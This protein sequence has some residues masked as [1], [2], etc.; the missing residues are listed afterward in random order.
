MSDRDDFL[1][2]LEARL[3]PAERALHD[4]DAE[5][6]FAIWSRSSPVTVLGAWKNANG[7]D[8]VAHLF[9]ELEDSF[10]DCRSYEFE[11]LVADVVGDMA[12]TVGYEHVRTSLWGKPRTFTLRASQAYRREAGDWKVAHRHADTVTSVEE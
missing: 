9:R 4:G 12:I 1:A 6:R 7:P 8:E 2:W 3:I 10:S 11:L 5:P